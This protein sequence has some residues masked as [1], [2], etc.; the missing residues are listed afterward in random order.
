MDQQVDVVVSGLH[1]PE[2]PVWMSD[3]HL[4][5]V[6]MFGERLTRTDPATGTTQVLAAIRGTPN[7][8]AV[9]RD[10]RLFVANSGYAHTGWRRDAAVA[11]QLPL[12]PGSIERVDPDG[13]VETLYTGCDGQYF[14]APNDIAL[15]GEGGAYFTDYYA[16]R[17]YYMRLDGT[18]VRSVA[19]DV[20]FANGLALDPTG[21]RLYVAEY[22]RGCVIAFEILANGDLGR[23]RDV[24]QL[25]PGGSP[26]G[27]CMDEAGYLLA[28]SPTSGVVCSF[29][30][31]GYL[32]LVLDIP[33]TLVTNL[34]F[35]GS[36]RDVLYLTASSAMPA[37]GAIDD[38]TGVVLSTA[39]PRPGLRLAT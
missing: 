11:R 12:I 21:T 16:H 9:D 5:V 17:V 36:S 28:A 4:V 25:P 22:R 1:A 31:D 18:Y 35:G 32:D 39:W 20:A 23:R 24:A 10:G 13:T 14:A 29:T 27:L 34:A 38:P 19:R 15:T 37:G 3:D 33:Y 7:G 26:D 2:G 30:P 6:E 8:A